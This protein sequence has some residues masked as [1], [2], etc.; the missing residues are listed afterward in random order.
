MRA[1]PSYAARARLGRD[2][3]RPALGSLGLRNPARA[4]ATRDRTKVLRAQL[5]VRTPSRNDHA[6]S[7]APTVVV[8]PWSRTMSIP[9]QDWNAGVHVRLVRTTRVLIGVPIGG[10][11][12]R[13]LLL[14]NRVVTGDSRSARPGLEPGTP[15]FSVV[16]SCPQNSTP[17]QAVPSSLAV[18]IDPDFPGSCVHSPRVTADWRIHRPFV[19]RTRDP[20]RARR[21][22]ERRP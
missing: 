1:S 15:R 12:P 9:Q 14:E 22:N 4:A 16:P 3:G 8:F 21:S 18:E 20:G 11:S 19:R 10:L 5:S 7:G 13:H 17:L 2:P 6:G